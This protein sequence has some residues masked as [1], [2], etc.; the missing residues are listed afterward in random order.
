M[1]ACLFSVAFVFSWEPSEKIIAFDFVLDVVK[2]DL[3][4]TDTP[5]YLFL[6]LAPASASLV[7]LKYSDRSRSTP[8]S[9]QDKLPVSFS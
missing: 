8:H 5:E 7:L 2:R 4:S 3:A 9:S 6:R 1:V